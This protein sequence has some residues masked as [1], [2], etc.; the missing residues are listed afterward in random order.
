MIFMDTITF[1]AQP[2]KT[3]EGYLVSSALAARTGIQLYRGIEVDPENQHGLRDRATVRVLRPEDEVFHKDAM[4]SFASIPVTDDHPNGEMVNAE[5]WRKYASGYTGEE[6]MRDGQ[7]MRVSLIIKDAA[8]INKVEGGKR[9]LSCGYYCDVDFTAG[10]TADG[11]EYDAKQTNIRG[12]HV[13]VVLKARGGETLKI[14]DTEVPK[15]I[16]FDGHTVEV[17]DAAAILF[18]TLTAKLDTATK[19]KDAAETKV[20]ELT[21]TL[22]IRDGTIAALEL[23]VKD[24][25]MTPAKLDQMVTERNKVITDAKSIFPDVVT[26]GVTATDIR[27]AAVAH[28]LGDKAPTDENGIKG[29]FDALAVTMPT[30]DTLAAASASRPATVIS[31]QAL[32]DGAAKAE[33]AR[34]E[35]IVHMQ[36]P[37]K[38]N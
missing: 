3:K 11:L 23:K 31:P 34:N 14:G 1:D 12:N 26:D 21:A 24:G 38:A 15:N 17:N 35:M 37:G 7:S 4:A 25:E 30:V 36:N 29:A 8:L 22:A 9:E 28:K 6:V 33:A 5:T 18:D 2:R 13:A 27:K 20:G 19:A 32:A 10:V 16:T